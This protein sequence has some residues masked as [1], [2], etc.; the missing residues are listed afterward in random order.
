MRIVCFLKD[1]T[2]EPACA[3]H[4][5][6]QGK[7]SENGTQRDKREMGGRHPMGAED[8]WDE[9]KDALESPNSGALLGTTNLSSMA[10]A[11]RNPKMHEV[12]NSG[13]S[14]LESRPACSGLL[15]APAYRLGSCLSPWPGALSYQT[16][17]K[18]PFP[19]YTG[20]V[21]SPFSTTRTQDSESSLLFQVL[22]PTFLS[23]SSLLAQF[24]NVPSRP[25]QDSC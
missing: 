11:V 15:P 13:S 5:M 7:G 20:M 8:R 10:R 25:F 22:S 19:A 21:L 14:S 17:K 24:P 23:A 1:G 2:C 12:W 16:L 9:V 4:K 18:S 3:Q 6:L